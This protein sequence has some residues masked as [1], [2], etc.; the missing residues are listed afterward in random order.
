MHT[1][2]HPQSLSVWSTPGAFLWLPVLVHAA[3]GAEIALLAFDRAR[4]MYDGFDGFDVFW[5]ILFFSVP[6]AA[7]VG[8]GWLL[9]A[10]LRHKVNAQSQSKG[11]RG[12]I[13][14][15]VIGVLG[16]ILLYGALRGAL[17]I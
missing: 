2:L 13:L 6:V 9:M 7:V 4:G 10:I 11:G 12:C 5:H 16:P 17:A 14:L 1:A 3:I 8:G 15:G